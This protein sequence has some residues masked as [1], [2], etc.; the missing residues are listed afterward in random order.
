M[1]VYWILLII[2][3]F[4]AYCMG[5]LS[6]LSIASVLVY[7]KN[8]RK[9]GRGNIWL[10]N[11]RRIYGWKGLVTLLLLEMLKDLLPILL[12]GLLL[13]IKEQAL[14][15]RAF[16]G[17]C[18]IMGRLWPVFNRFKGS[19]GIGCLIV[20][21]FGV[22]AALGGAAL[23]FFAGLLWYKRSMSLACAVAVLLFMAASLV[24]I[25]ENLVM[26]LCLFMGTII[27]IRLMPKLVLMFKG[28]EPKLSFKED[29]SYKFDEKF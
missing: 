6:T 29:I 15:G 13:G 16:A 3:A 12:G 28:Q 27:I 5:S 1:T 22:N 2:V 10:S 21:A 24:I 7:R 17:F 23:V 26:T 18:L 9:L 19:Y 8:L 14:V 20:A 11:F 25:D 4:V